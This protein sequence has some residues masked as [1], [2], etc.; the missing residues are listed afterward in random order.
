MDGVRHI[1]ENK[2]IPLNRLMVETDAP[3]MYPNTRG[4]KLPENIKSCL[5][6][7]SLRFGTMGNFNRNEPCCLP[8]TLEMIAGYLDMKP[9]D[10]ALQTS[11]N[12]L[13]IFGLNT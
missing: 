1:L 5:T 8:L 11:F 10:V 9:E 3:Y 4:A 13:K 12:A 7:K 2:L 6:S